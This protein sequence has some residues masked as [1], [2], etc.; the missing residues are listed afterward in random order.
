MNNEARE[1][2]CIFLP[3]ISF[4][5]S[6][7][8][9]TA[10]QQ[11]STVLQRLQTRV[12]KE[13]IRSQVS[14]KFRTARRAGNMLT[15]Q[16]Y[17]LAILAIKGAH[18]DQSLRRRHSSVSVAKLGRESIVRFQVNGSEDNRAFHAIITIRLIGTPHA[19]SKRMTA[20][21]PSVDA[22]SV[23]LGSDIKFYD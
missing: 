5:H 15:Q 3:L 4:I 23:A 2:F 16:C 6:V 13:V 18:E 11:R 20:V 8:L 22:V 19:I 14:A 10:W 21:D 9:V 7:K 1:E 12:F 17:S